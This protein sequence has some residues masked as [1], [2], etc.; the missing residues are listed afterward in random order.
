MIRRFIAYYLPVLT[1]RDKWFKDNPPLKVDDL[2]LL[3][4]PNRT[5]TAWERAKIIK[6][7]KSRDNKGRVADI[8]MPDGTIRPR[9]SV[10]RLAKLNLQTRA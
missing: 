2:V 7:Y 3:C 8:Q 5:R 6:I 1:K 4:D 10:N 9:R